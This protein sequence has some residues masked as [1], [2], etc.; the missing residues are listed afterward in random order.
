MEET[1]TDDADR[2]A[3]RG[4]SKDGSIGF[5]EHNDAGAGVQKQFDGATGLGRESEA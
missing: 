4:V 3:W 5:T 1:L 2:F